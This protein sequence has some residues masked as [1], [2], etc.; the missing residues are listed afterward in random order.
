MPCD[1]RKGGPTRIIG[2]HMAHTRQHGSRSMMIAA[3]LVIVAITA[4]GV[5]A[6]SG[7]GSSTAQSPTATP[8]PTGRP[9]PYARPI[10]TADDAITRTLAALPDTV[11]VQGVEARLVTSATLDALWFQEGNPAWMGSSPL[12]IV[13]VSSDTVTLG[14]TIQAQPGSPLVSDTTP[15]TG[16]F[17]IWNASSGRMVSSG[18][19]D[20]YEYGDATAAALGTPTI[21]PDQTF[22]YDFSL[23]RFHALPTTVATVVTATALPDLPPDW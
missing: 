11:V 13:V 17:F 12:W 10:V 21:P 1:F 8:P 3:A 16:A 23:E 5:V 4:L 22:R 19:L 7:S 9:D 20:Y 18:G 14:D 2:D 15:V 6:L